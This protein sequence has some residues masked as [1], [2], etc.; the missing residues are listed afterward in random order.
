MEKRQLLEEMLQVKP[1]EAENLKKKK[2][3]LTPKKTNLEVKL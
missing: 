3:M 2:V 1:K